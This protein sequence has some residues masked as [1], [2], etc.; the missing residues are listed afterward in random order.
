MGRSKVSHTIFK[1]V[2]KLALAI[3]V[4]VLLNIAAP[5]KPLLPSCAPLASMLILLQ[6]PE[7]IITGYI[8]TLLYP[9]E[10]ENWVVHGKVA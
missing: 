9:F 2:I 7:G 1:S 4:A 10:Y 3:W 8:E 5:K 6:D